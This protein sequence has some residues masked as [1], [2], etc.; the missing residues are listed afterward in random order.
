MWTHSQQKDLGQRGAALKPHS[1]SANNL[2][3]EVPA[4]RLP[5]PPLN[6]SGPPTPL[7][8]HWAHTQNDGI[9]PRHRG[10]A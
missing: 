2:V 1:P 10:L 7:G 9:P 6:S 4:V 5:S 3:A 8:S